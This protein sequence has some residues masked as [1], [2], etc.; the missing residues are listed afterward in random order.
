MPT[1]IGLRIGNSVR[2]TLKEC[3]SACSEVE[4]CCIL[5]VVVGESGF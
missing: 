4:N 2:L 1:A 5:G 3:K